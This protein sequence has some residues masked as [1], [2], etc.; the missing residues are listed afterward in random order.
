VL[1]IHGEAG[2][3]GIEAL[4]LEATTGKALELALRGCAAIAVKPSTWLPCSM[5]W[6]SWVWNGDGSSGPM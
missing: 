2:R 4:M 3:M 6:S 5:G 1:D